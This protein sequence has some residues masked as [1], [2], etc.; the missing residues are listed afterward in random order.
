[1]QGEAGT[2]PAKMRLQAE[3]ADR[4]HVVASYE[5]QLIAARR[6]PDNLPAYEVLYKTAEEVEHK[7]EEKKKLQE[8]AQMEVGQPFFH[9]FGSSCSPA[10][11]SFLHG[12]ALC[13]SGRCPG[14]T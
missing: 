4:G 7:R 10:Q 3:A 1:M 6:R 11:R 12:C 2:R 14:G 5:L 9:G 13:I 8:M